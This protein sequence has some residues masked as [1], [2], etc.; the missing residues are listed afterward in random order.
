[1]PID[2]HAAAM[3]VS[4]LARARMPDSKAMARERG[5]HKR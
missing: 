2:S 5:D 1:M 4:V 3:L